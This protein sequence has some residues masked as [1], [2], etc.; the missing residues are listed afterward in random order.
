MAKKKLTAIAAAK[1]RAEATTREVPDA[2]T[3]GLRL[4]IYPSGR[5]TWIMRFR[6]PDKKQ[7][8]LTLGRFTEEEVEGELE[9]GKPLT[10]S[11]AR[12]LAAEVNRKRALGQDPAAAHVRARVEQRE[13]A[14]RAAENTFASAARLYTEKYTRPRT[15]K[16][17]KT[18]REVA[19]LFG[20]LVTDDGVE[21]IPGGLAE[22][23]ADRPVTKITS[24]DVDALL[25][26]CRNSG[27][28]G[29]ERRSKKV[30]ESQARHMFGALNRLFKWLRATR[31]NN[32]CLA[33]E[34]PSSW[35]ARDRVLSDDEIRWFWAAC[36]ETGMAFGKLFKLLLVTGQRR[37]EVGE[38]RWSELSSDGSTWT[39]PAERVKNQRR[40]EVPLSALARDILA[41]IERVEGSDYVFTT[42]GL[43][44]L[45][46]YSTAK[47]RLDA[48]M[49]RLAEGASI[50]PW[51]LHDLRRTAVSGMARA[52]ADLHIIERAVNH[53]SG[54]FGGIVGTYQKHKYE[55]EVRQAHEAWS[56]L[57]MSIVEGR[58]ASNVVEL[59][60]RV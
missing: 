4:A 13:Q 20:L 52:G 53:V 17:P 43:K 50:E 9:I 36:G 1:L 18:K 51:V 25:D 35:A 15:G 48:A 56:R 54:S 34:R 14:R 55:N 59:R 58:V 32:P 40:H 10:L 47:Y 19:R 29:A 5:R 26:E 57:L 38:M 3:P 11:A 7:A 8:K 33:A 46:G 16:E 31:K 41:S 49:Q 30:T 37:D 23:W 42:T 6:R 27:V 28:P 60:E 24:D 22:R 44:P 21:I 39:L 2:G 12:Q 45:A